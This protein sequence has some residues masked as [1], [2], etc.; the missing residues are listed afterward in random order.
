MGDFFDQFLPGERRTTQKRTAG[1]VGGRQGRR[2]TDRGEAGTGTGLPDDRTPST[3][4]NMAV[5]TREAITSFRAYAKAKVDAS[6]MFGNED[7]GTNTTLTNFR[8]YKHS[9][10]KKYKGL[11]ATVRRYEQNQDNCSMGDQEACG[12]VGRRQEGMITERPFYDR[13]KNIAN[14]QLRDVDRNA[15]SDADTFVADRALTQ[16]YTVEAPPPEQR[17]GAGDGSAPADDPEGGAGDGAPQRTAEQQCTDSGGRYDSDR[18]VC[19]QEAPTVPGTAPA[20][21]PHT[22]KPE[23][24]TGRQVPEDTHTR[25]DDQQHRSSESGGGHHSGA[26]GSKT[27]AGS[28][29]VVHFD[30]GG[31]GQV[32]ISDKPHPVKEML[33]RLTAL[34]NPYGEFD[35]SCPIENKRLVE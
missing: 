6:N 1:H 3:G 13:F 5:P 25:H 33:A 15:T 23:D 7:I 20:D 18:G 12:R 27:H 22:D 4:E 10:M 31:R 28:D 2:G 35:F 34:K 16:N 26:D 32:V 14:A 17:A 19:F 9:D 24:R 30:T 8:F 29:E 11:V 21:D